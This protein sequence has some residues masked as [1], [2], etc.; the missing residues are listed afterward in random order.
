MSVLYH[1]GKANDVT[2]DLSR[3]TM[4][5]VSHV[6]EGMKDLA[7]DDH[8]LDRLGV[9][10]EDPPNGGFMV[11]NNFKSSLVFEVKSKQ[12]LDPLLIEL[13]K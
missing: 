10:L 13:K 9:W 8:R 6:E 5:S 4:G 2:D 3:M 11:Y 1:L 7:K 12:H